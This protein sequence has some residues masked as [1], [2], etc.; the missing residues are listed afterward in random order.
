MARIFIPVLNP[1]THQPKIENC[2]ILTSSDGLLYV[3]FISGD[4]GVRTEQSRFV[5]LH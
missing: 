1:D 3:S 2:V 4:S 5:M